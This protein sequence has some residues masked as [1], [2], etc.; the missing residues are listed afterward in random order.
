MGILY[1][2]DGKIIHK[3]CFKDGKKQ[4]EWD[5]NGRRKVYS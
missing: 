1:D 2:K 5:Y 3:G 4:D